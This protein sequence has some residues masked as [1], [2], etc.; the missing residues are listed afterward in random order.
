MV[1]EEPRY[2]LDFLSAKKQNFNKLKTETISTKLSFFNSEKWLLVYGV[3]C[4]L[5]TKIFMIEGS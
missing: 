4:D 5:D 1:G 3:K 2:K